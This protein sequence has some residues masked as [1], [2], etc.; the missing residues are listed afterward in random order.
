MLS[1]VRTLRKQCSSADVAKK[2]PAV[3]QSLEVVP[4]SLD[5]FPLVDVVIDGKTVRVPFPDTDYRTTTAGV[6]K[7]ALEASNVFMRTTT[8][9]GN[10]EY[11]LV[12]YSVPDRPD[13]KKPVTLLREDTTF[14]DVR[15]EKELTTDDF[16]KCAHFL[17]HEFERSFF[18]VSNKYDFSEDSDD[19][20]EF[21]KLARHGSVSVDVDMRSI[22]P[23]FSLG[24]RNRIFT[25]Y[26]RTVRIFAQVVVFNKIM[27]TFFRNPPQKQIT[28]NKQQ[29]VED[30]GFMK[31]LKECHEHTINI[32]SIINNTQAEAKTL[33]AQFSV[34]TFETE[35]IDITK[36]DFQ[37]GLHTV[38]DGETERSESHSKDAK[39][40]VTSHIYLSNSKSA[41][42]RYTPRKKDVFHIKI[43]KTTL[44]HFLTSDAFSVRVRENITDATIRSRILG[45]GARVSHDLLYYVC[46]M[47]RAMWQ[48]HNSIANWDKYAES[49][50]PSK[51][52]QPSVS[53]EDDESTESEPDS[54]TV[55][56]LPP[57]KKKRVMKPKDVRDKI[58]LFNDFIKKCVELLQTK[59]TT[60]EDT[61]A[62]LFGKNVCAYFFAAGS[63]YDGVKLERDLCYFDTEIMDNV[64]IKYEPLTPTVSQEEVFQNNVYSNYDEARQTPR[65]FFWNMG[66]G[67]TFLMC[68]TVSN[69]RDKIIY[70]FAPT[71]VMRTSWVSTVLKHTPMKN[72]NITQGFVE[73]NLISHNNFDSTKTRHILK[74][75][76]EHVVIVDEIHELYPAPNA[77]FKVEQL[78]KFELLAY[79]LKPTL[80]KNGVVENNAPALFF[81]SG[82]P[83]QQYIPLHTLLLLNALTPA[84]SA[85]IYST[86]VNQD[87]GYHYAL[88]KIDSVL[89]KKMDLEGLQRDFTK[90]C[91]TDICRNKNAFKSFSFFMGYVFFLKTFSN[92]D[93]AAQRRLEAIKKEILKTALSFVQSSIFS[94]HSYDLVTSTTQRMQSSL[95]ERIK[96]P[97]TTRVL[98]PIRQPKLVEPTKDDYMD[99]TLTDFSVNMIGDRTTYRFSEI[100]KFIQS[101]KYKRVVMFNDYVGEHVRGSIP[102]LI[103]RIDTKKFN[104]VEFATLADPASFKDSLENPPG[105][106]GAPDDARQMLIF[107]SQQ[108]ISGISFLNCDALVFLATIDAANIGTILQIEARVVR[109]CSHKNTV[110]KEKRKVDIVYP[111]LLFE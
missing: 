46:V 83:I 58:K 84:K 22:F 41:L 19:F 55:S 10:N 102:Q 108:S 76:T 106:T 97:E 45:N 75:P 30:D 68:N 34:C 52:K 70:V 47:L 16:E 44:Y 53:T 85:Y 5:P 35:I 6:L 12:K 56:S 107:I 14:I 73:W 13:I 57:P 43:I 98:L 26:V 59:C 36:K 24:K 109:L 86:L 88:D 42:Y 87:L 66:T 39:V 50:A 69:Y 92:A 101:K 89:S 18:G 74:T 64:F 1:L 63:S 23:K 51:H 49:I 111:Y 60:S 25:D 80:V 31:M 99:A 27:N 77:K 96:F 48:K 8:K 105:T 21:W 104:C 20:E 100:L 3:A 40:V 9:K 72:D 103:D 79:G 94:V 65:L 81:L 32:Q 11:S 7:M 95:L 90:Q 82:T 29:S 91:T 78:D 38:N 15:N 28:P 61:E 17:F 4:F 71:V 93:A 110:D 37:T 33:P 54:S 67:K 2:T 62:L